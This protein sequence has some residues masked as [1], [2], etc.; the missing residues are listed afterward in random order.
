[1]VYRSVR[2]RRGEGWRRLPGDDLIAE[3][4]DSLTHAITIRRP[5]HEV[6]P[7]LVQMG[8]D[9]AGWY[10]YDAIDNGGRPSAEQ[11]MPE[12]QQVR[13]GDVFPAAPGVKE[14]FVL[15]QLETERFLVLGWLLPDGTPMMTWAFVLEDAGE[16]QTRLLVRARA[17]KSYRPPFGL[18]AWTARSLL[19]LGHFIMQRKQLLGI[20]RRVEESP[21]PVWEYHPIMPTLSPLLLE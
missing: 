21:Q 12:L 1:M 20:A 3:E 9:R 13:V 11:I 19:P 4:T 8:A 10:S 14:G 5:R 16:N 18:P 7:W 17:G 6:W 15:L 2:A